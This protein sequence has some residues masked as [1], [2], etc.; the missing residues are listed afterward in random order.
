MEVESSPVGNVE[1]LTYIDEVSN[2]GMV[3]RLEITT[4]ID[5]VV[6][7]NYESNSKLVNGDFISHQIIFNQNEVERE[8]KGNLF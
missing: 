7:F 5:D 6:P 2:S 1:M 8:E 3:I 4:Y